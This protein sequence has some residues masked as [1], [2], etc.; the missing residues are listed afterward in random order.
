MVWKHPFKISMALVNVFERGKVAQKSS[1][2][3]KWLKSVEN[4]RRSNPYRWIDGN[5]TEKKLEKQKIAHTHASVCDINAI[6][7][8]SQSL[9]RLADCYYYM[10]VKSATLCVVY[11]TQV[12]MSFSSL[13]FLFFLKKAKTTQKDGNSTCRM[14]TARKLKAL[15]HSQ[16]FYI[17]SFSLSVTPHS[18]IGCLRISFMHFR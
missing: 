9:R 1:T 3:E 6:T 5:Q 18:C 2:N 12:Q 10:I 7:R 14:Q 17:T 4:R 15:M 13:F 11:K 8:L 16:L